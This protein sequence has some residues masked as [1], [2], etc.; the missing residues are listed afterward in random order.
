[1]GIHKVY[2]IFIINSITKLGRS[3]RGAAENSPINAGAQPCFIA[4]LSA[5]ASLCPVRV[6][7]LT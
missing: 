2:G 7:L 3:A 5:L 4:L 1:M 6:L